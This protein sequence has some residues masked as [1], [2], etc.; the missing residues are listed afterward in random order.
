MLGW[1]R[2]GTAPEERPRGYREADAPIVGDIDLRRAPRRS[3]LALVGHLVK[4]ALAA[5]M[6]AVLAFDAHTAP[7]T[8]L[9]VAGYG[10]WPFGAARYLW[11]TRRRV[12][13]V[14]VR[15]DGQV[16]LE[17]ARGR[18]W[19]TG[20]L[21]LLRRPRFGSRGR[22]RAWDLGLKLEGTS[23]VLD[24]LAG[25]RLPDRLRSALE[26]A[27]GEP[28]LIRGHRLGN[29]RDPDFRAEAMLPPAQAPT[30]PVPVRAQLVVWRGRALSSFELALPLVP[31][32]LALLFVIGWMTEEGTLPLRPLVG[33]SLA[34]AAFTVAWI[35]FRLRRRRDVTLER[36]RD[37]VLVVRDGMTL[38]RLPAKAES[39]GWQV[40]GR[41]D[42]FA[43]QLRDA[44]GNVALTLRQPSA[45]L[46]ATVRGLLEV[47]SSVRARV[48]AEAAAED[49]PSHE[50]L[51]AVRKPLAKAS[52]G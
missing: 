49:S 40:G 48:D 20:R 5:F 45:D 47:P 43:L 50:A 17:R 2:S 24:V 18:G 12:E 9:I 25:H 4:S 16:A 27:G 30:H 36:V 34:F 51:P 3:L 29:V 33:G 21:S 11:R 37:E 52:P 14:L 26:A 31:I 44:R 39:L 32:G 13:R 42:V 22:K 19:L 1:F 35:A 15:S 46:V 28:E 23:G 7:F 10:L 38:A 8:L 41:G 6:I